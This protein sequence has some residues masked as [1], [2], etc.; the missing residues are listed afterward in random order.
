MGDLPDL[1]TRAALLVERLRA[2]GAT[3]VTATTHPVWVTGCAPSGRRFQIFWWAAQ[4][5]YQVSRRNPGQTA[6]EVL[7]LFPAWEAAVARALQA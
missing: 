6:A 4:Q 3:D 7:G 1:T 5:G 2:G